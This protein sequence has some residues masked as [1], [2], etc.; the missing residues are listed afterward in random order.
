M[1]AHEELGY[2]VVVGI[3]R[4]T[5]VRAVAVLWLS[6][7]LLQNMAMD[8]TNMGNMLLVLVVAFASGAVTAAL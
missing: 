7:P 8:A 4:A 6:T 5:V 1:A 2:A 3:V